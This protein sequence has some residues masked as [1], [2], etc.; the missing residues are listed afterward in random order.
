MT[1]ALFCGLCTLDVNQR[2]Q[3]VPGPNEK[4]V[5]RSTAIDVGG[6]ATNAARTASALG[7]EAVLV[8]ALGLGA[9][10][11]AARSLLDE[12]K[13]EVRAVSLDGELPVSSVFS[14]DG[15]HRSVASTNLAGRE[16]GALTDEETAELLEGTAVLEVD[17]H[18][19]G[20][21][22][23]LARAARQR[24]IPVVL[25]G[26]S[27]KNGLDALLPF[28]SHAILSADFD[29]PEGDTIRNVVDHGATFVAQ[30]HGESSVVVHHPEPA[31][32]EIEVVDVVDSLGAGDVLHG[33]FAA[34]LAQ[35]VDD[36]EA[37]TRATQI[38]T[39]SVRHS[40]AMGWAHA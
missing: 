5:A 40:G 33:A 27:Y 16:T 15:G 30:S 21:Q 25:D 19:L 36:T 28:V 17:G 11:D 8:T 20:V 7:I 10:A 26:G 9:G 12:A 18:L 14:D 34:Y 24:G 4:I 37:L 31:T 38:A 29:T 35:D 2:V 39:M 32:I 23:P 13:V 22:V 1:K 3:R 6:P